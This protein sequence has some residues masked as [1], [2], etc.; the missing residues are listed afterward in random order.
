MIIQNQN[1]PQTQGA[2]DGA[3]HSNPLP[4]L[5]EPR[6]DPIARVKRRFNMLK[7]EKSAWS[8]K[9]D[10]LARFILGRRNYMSHWRLA[11]EDYF[12]AW[13]FDDT[14]FNA[15]HLMASALIGALWPSGGKTFYFTAP[16]DPQDPSLE[17]D[18]TKAYYEQVTRTVIEALDHPKAGFGLAL[19]EYEI[20]KGALG[21]GAIF[22]E[23]T[24]DLTMPCTYRVINAKDLYIDVNHLNTVDTIYIDRYMFMN[25]VASAYGLSS[26]TDEEMQRLDMHDYTNRNQVVIAIEP[27][28]QY[29]PQSLGNEK[30][31]YSAVHVDITR[32]KILRVGGFHELPVF[33][34]RF[35]HLLGEKYGR[36]PGMNALPSIREL[37]QLRYLTIKTSEKMLDPALVVI[38]GSVLGNDEVDDSPG[39]LTVVSISGKMQGNMKPVD[40]LLEIGDPSWAFQRLAELIKIVQDHFFQDRLMDLNNKTRQTLGEAEIRNDLRGQSLNN[41]FA[42]DYVEVIQPI[43]ERT[44]NICLG[45]KL[46]GVVQ[47]SADDI[48]LQQQGITPFYIPNSLVHRMASGKE[49]YKIK[50]IS[51]AQRI[52]ESE[53]FSGIQRALQLGTT[54]AQAGSPEIMDNFDL[55]FTARRAIELAGGPPL[56]IKSE[57][58]VSET[59]QQRQ[60][61]QMQ[62]QQM[63]AAQIQ[64][65]TAKD[66]AKAVKDVSSAGPG[67]GTPGG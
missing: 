1:L 38:D 14:A 35:W 15:N 53:E 50:F 32:N 22:V 55:D 17:S 36:S 43:I 37:N 39:G 20:E 45:K 58:A 60:Q 67:G 9:Y 10:I 62:A 49:V 59:R 65:A 21:T 41:V 44:F 64:A 8:N 12:D 42:R 66:G 30:F 27:N 7:T 34:G 63:Q 31:K 25:Q 51:P 13:I 54:V 4:N 40:K 47:G 52:R 11:P 19:E 26:F 18:E 16:Y 29:D 3:P 46:L 48:M 23:E 57:Q 2:I 61:A 56:M 33:V 6:N 24:D 28:N 5:I